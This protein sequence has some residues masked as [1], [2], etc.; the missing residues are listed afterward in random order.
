MKKKA[1][2]LKTSPSKSLY[3]NTLRGLIGLENRKSVS[4]ERKS[5]VNEMMPLLKV[6][7]RVSA[8]KNMPK[9]IPIISIFRSGIVSRNLNPSLNKRKSPI[10]NA[11]A[12]DETI[13]IFSMDRP[14]LPK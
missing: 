8:A 9:S 1:H 12:K 6:S 4:L 10:Q 13:T 3:E 14:A 2:E 11:T 7:M 5:D